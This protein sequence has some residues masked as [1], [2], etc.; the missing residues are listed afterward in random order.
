MIWGLV[1][2]ASALIV[3]AGFFL[4]RR[5]RRNYDRAVKSFYENYERMRS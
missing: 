3:I 2:A 1:S 5:E 4:V